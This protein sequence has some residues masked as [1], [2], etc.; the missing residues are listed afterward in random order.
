MTVIA[1]ASPKGSPGVTTTAL[2]L[3]TAWPEGAVVADLDP[4]GGD[5]L[6]RSRRR[7]GA[8]LDPDR[9]LL[10]LGAA[11]RRGA[12]GTHLVDHLQETATGDVLVGVR[13]PEQIAGLGG[14]WGQLPGVLRKHPQDVMA[15]CGRLMPSSPAMP[16]L[17][18][19]DV[20]C[21]VVRPDLE[22]TAHLRERLTALRDTLDLGRPGGTPVGV[23]LAASYK[24]THVV[25]EMQQLLE[26]Q[27]LPATVLGIMAE[28][29][30]GAAVVAAKRSGRATLLR[31]S[32][33]TLA[34]RIAALA[35]S[36]TTV[37]GL[38]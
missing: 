37:G 9:G 2:A 8:P 14:A 1:L 30:R 6:W 12:E 27:D 26:S 31:R 10:S 28:D 22:G 4:V 24:D 5:V 13:A 25:D 17:Q 7:D 18:Q 15:D 3:A 35:N 36:R 19:A 33:V 23:V 38:R 32:A 21:F 34:D 29:P 16:V 11:L 20:V